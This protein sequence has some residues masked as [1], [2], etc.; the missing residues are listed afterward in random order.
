MVLHKIV[1]DAYMILGKERNWNFSKTWR[2][3][4]IIDEQIKGLQSTE[5]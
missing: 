1:S 2:I 4:L 5:E 3:P